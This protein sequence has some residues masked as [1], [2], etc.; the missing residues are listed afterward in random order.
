M[1]SPIEK[2]NW[3]LVTILCY[4]RFSFL[5]RRSVNC[6]AVYMR[7]FSELDLFSLLLFCRITVV[8]RRDVVTLLLLPLLLLLSP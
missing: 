7:G 1:R 4:F 3:T 5:N 2:K 8:V 6:R